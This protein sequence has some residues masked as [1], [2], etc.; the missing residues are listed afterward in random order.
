MKCL[1]CF[2]FLALPVC[3][4][5]Q[6][7]TYAHKLVD[8]LTSEIFS[9]RGYVNS[10]D[11]NA[12][13]FIAGEYR[14]FGL[15]SF[16]KGYFQTF[17][18]PV[19]TFPGKMEVELDETSLLPGIDYIVNPACSSISGSFNIIIINTIPALTRPK[20]VKNK[21][22]C[23]DKSQCKTKEESIALD[24][25]LKDIHG[26]S[27]IIFIEEKNLPGVYQLISKLFRLFIY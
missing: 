5:S 25:W 10:G 2:L 27:G 15:D 20:K 1:I 18:F 21:F 8:T 4:F 6:D 9:G 26:A 7:L 23:I 19:N 16:E 22:I 11:K 3:G 12:A 14:K 17:D 13:E 24:A